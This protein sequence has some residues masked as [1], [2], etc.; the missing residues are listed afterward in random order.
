MH[1][2]PVPRDLALDPDPPLGYCCLPAASLV[3][4]PCAKHGAELMEALGRGG[5]DGNAR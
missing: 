1:A 5:W 2:Y 4:R 3:A